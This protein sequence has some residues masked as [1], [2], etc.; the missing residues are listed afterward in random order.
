MLK[1]LLFAIKWA[2]NPI[3]HDKCEGCKYFIC[4]EDAIKGEPF[5]GYYNRKIKYSGFC[6]HPFKNSVQTDCAW[7]NY[8]CLNKEL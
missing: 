8:G 2:L 4:K 6:K 1:R 7:V 3:N 5:P